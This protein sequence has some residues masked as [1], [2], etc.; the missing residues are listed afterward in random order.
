[1]PP[2]PAF[3]NVVSGNLTAAGSLTIADADQGQAAFV[4]QATAA[5]SYGTFSLAADGAWTY[6]ASNSQ[7]AVQQLGAGQSL[8]DSFTAVS[9][10]GSA[11]RVV[12][13]TIVGANDL[14]TIGGVSTGSVTEDAN[15]VAGNLTAAGSL[16]IAD[17]D[18]GQAA[19]VAQAAAA[20]GA[21]LR[22]PRRRPSHRS[23][24]K[25]PCT[26]RGPH[27]QRD[28]RERLWRGFVAPP[29]R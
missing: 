9:L 3:A 25:P 1:M 29:L 10:D 2:A 20:L 14:A 16:S 6:T 11:S 15:V 13:V 26:T 4:A 19:F 21:I 12:S 23:S 27:A 18:Q 24:V 22:L 8:V 7:A 5:G 17:P 28:A